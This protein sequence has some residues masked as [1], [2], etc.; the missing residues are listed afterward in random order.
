MSKSN[1]LRPQAGAQCEFMNIP[2][3]IPLVFYG[4]AA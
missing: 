4:G 1:I 2:P 3:E